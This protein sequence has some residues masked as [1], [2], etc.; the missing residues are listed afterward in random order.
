MYLLLYNLFLRLYVGVAKLMAF[1]NAKAAAW[2][3]GRKHTVRDLQHWKKSNSKPVIWI[4]AASL[5]EFEQGKPI[6]E[7]IRQQYP[8]YAILISFFSPSGLEPSKHYP[9]AD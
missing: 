3:A 7:S 6:I 8:N 1:R 4:H 9:H 5:G 2:V